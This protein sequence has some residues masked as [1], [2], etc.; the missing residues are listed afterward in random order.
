MNALPNLAG[1]ATNDLVEKI[2][3]SGFQASYINWS[4][5]LHLLRTHAP[6][7]LPELVASADGVLHA[8]PVGA[9]L[10]I[11]FRHLDG[12]VTPEV[13]QAI[14]DSRNAAIP[15]AKITARDITDTHRR[16]V[17][18]AAALIFGLAYELWA[19]MPL[20]S[21]YVDEKDHSER[22]Q[23]SKPART[24]TGKP[25][26]DMRI[27]DMPEDRQ[28]VIRQCVT[29]ILAMCDDGRLNEACAAWK[30]APLSHEEKAALWFELPSVHRTAITKLL[31]KAA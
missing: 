11:R 1:V 13:P 17:C 25:Q 4:R 27:D 9:Y 7:W 10:L 24:H 3:G 26:D 22:A 18:M 14:M 30:G 19:K 23:E 2:G 12:S 5:T 16:G 6:G 15:L 21:G 31:R 29:D 20:E 28:P 8:A